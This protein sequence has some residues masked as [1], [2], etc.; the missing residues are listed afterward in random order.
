MRDSSKVAPRMR[1]ATGRSVSVGCVGLTDPAPRPLNILER[2]VNAGRLVIRRVDEYLERRPL[3]EWVH[4]LQRWTAIPGSGHLDGR[5]DGGGD[6]RGCLLCLHPDGD[7][8]RADDRAGG[9][10]NGHA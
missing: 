9:V 5:G 7:G 10:G 2:I 3:S 8:D 1:A 6:G 4:H